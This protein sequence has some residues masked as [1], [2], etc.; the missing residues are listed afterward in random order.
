MNSERGIRELTNLRDL[1]SNMLECIFQPLLSEIGLGSVSDLL[2]PGDT[3]AG[4]AAIEAL[5]NAQHA[6]ALACMEG[7][8]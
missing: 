1:I 7:R 6:V 8:C 2:E 3:R 4:A 5:I